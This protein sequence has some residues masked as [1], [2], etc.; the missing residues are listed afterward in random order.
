VPFLRH[1][2]LLR[3]GRAQP[4]IQV[5]RRMCDLSQSKLFSGRSNHMNKT[6]QTIFWLYNY[7]DT[8]NDKER[9][10]DA[11][12]PLANVQAPMLL[13]VPDGLIRL[14]L[15][16]QWRAPRSDV[17]CMFFSAAAPFFYWPRSRHPMPATITMSRQI[18]RPCCK[19]SVS[20]GRNVTGAPTRQSTKICGPGF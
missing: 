8:E 15:S 6:L 20:I 3:R 16:R 9:F 1:L 14:M 17:S 12:D 2:K 18:K 5:C 7:A 19:R 4:F 10:E 13:A 11:S